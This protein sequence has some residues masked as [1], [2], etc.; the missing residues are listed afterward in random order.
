MIAAKET[1]KQKEVGYFMRWLDELCQG[2]ERFKDQ[3]TKVL[4][5]VQLYLTGKLTV[6]TIDRDYFHTI[7]FIHE[8][9]KY[10]KDLKKW[11]KEF[12]AENAKADDYKSLHATLEAH[13]QHL[14]TL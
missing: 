9:C 2:D 8:V 3:I 6:Y 7:T 11:C 14:D 10:D 5:E 13:K 1:S 4:R 12:N